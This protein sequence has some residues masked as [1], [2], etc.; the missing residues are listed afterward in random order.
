MIVRV[1]DFAL[2]KTGKRG[3]SGEERRGRGESES[4]SVCLGPR[5]SEVHSLLARLL[6]SRSVVRTV[7]LVIGDFLRSFAPL[8]TTEQRNA[9][10]TAAPSVIRPHPCFPELNPRFR[11][12]LHLTP[13]DVITRTG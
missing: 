11:Q 9:A 6:R 5:Q 4:L 1:V 12:R 3:D 8:R 2:P 7:G 10:I 13:L